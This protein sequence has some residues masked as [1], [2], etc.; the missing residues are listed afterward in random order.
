MFGPA[1]LRLSSFLMFL[2]T[3]RHAQVKYIDMER[4][5]AHEAGMDTAFLKV[6]CP[7]AIMTRW[8]TVSAAGAHVD[9]GAARGRLPARELLSRAHGLFDKWH[10]F[11]SNENASVWDCHGPTP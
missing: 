11:P 3:L 7:E 4:K 9:E 1:E 10:E 6:R 2:R 8:H 5:I